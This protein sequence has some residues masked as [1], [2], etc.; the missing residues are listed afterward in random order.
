MWLIVG[1]GNPGSKYLLTR[2]NL[3]FM[4]LD[5]LVKSVGVRND[6]SKLEHKA[7][8]IN[9]LWETQPIKLA[10]PETFMN[11][12]GESVQPLAHFYKI[13]PDH[14]IVV[15]DELDLPFGRMQIKVKGG[16]GGHNGISSII[17]KLGTDEFIRLRLGIG[18]SPIAGMETADWVLQK[19]SKEDQNLL[20]DFLNTAVDA[21]ESIVFDGAMTAMN[22]FNKK[23]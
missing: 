10:K 18:R 12:S 3:G 15:H 8:T 19:F 23:A 9:F 2:H 14:I 7:N 17:E 20:P 22:T 4:A 13:P 21:I 16:A 11:L 1:L 5:Y 6:D